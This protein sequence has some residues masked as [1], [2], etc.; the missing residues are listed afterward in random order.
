MKNFCLFS[1]TITLLFTEIDDN[2]MCLN[3]INFRPVAYQYRCFLPVVMSKKVKLSIFKAV[4][5]PILIYGH[6]FWVMTERVQSQVQAPEMRFLRRI[7][8][9]RF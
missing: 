5:V 2:K 6:E 8:R 9:K 1:I 4:F 3:N 7:L